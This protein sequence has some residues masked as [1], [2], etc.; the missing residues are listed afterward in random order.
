MYALRLM[1]IKA[2]NIQ[3]N[4]SCVWVNPKRNPNQRAKWLGLFYLVNCGLLL[5]FLSMLLGS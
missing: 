3:L 1:G 2:M 4:S 5:V